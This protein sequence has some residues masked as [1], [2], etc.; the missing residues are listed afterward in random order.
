MRS[1]YYCNINGKFGMGAYEKPDFPE[2]SDLLAH[3]DR[4]GV[5]QTVAYV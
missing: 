1:P 3:M 2:L 4:L 5:W